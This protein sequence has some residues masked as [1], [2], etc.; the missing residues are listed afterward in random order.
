M[1]YPRAS[2]ALRQAP[3]PMLKRAHFTHTTLLRTIGNLG[4]S[5]SGPLPPIKSWIRPWTHRQTTNDNYYGIWKQFN[6]F[7]IRLDNKSERWEDRLVLF[8][9]HLIDTG[10]C[11][12]PTLKSYISAIKSILASEGIEISTQT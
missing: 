6:Q 10:E 3:D 2:R 8:V 9:A 12:S 11:Q 1:K 7:F 4:L 5:R